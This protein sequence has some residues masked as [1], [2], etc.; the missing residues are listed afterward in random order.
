M[1]FPTDMNLF[2]MR[3]RLHHSQQFLNQVPKMPILDPGTFLKP[4]HVKGGK[5]IVFLTAGMIVEKEFQGKKRDAFEILIGFDGDKQKIW[6]M[7]DTAQ[8]VVVARFGDNT[9]EWISKQVT[10]DTFNKDVFG[11][12][13][14]IIFVVEQNVAQAQSPKASTAIGQGMQPVGGAATPI[15]QPINPDA[16]QPMDKLVGVLGQNRATMAGRQ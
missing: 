11:V 8:E 13:K 16:N 12:M 2:R 10:L 6:S 14:E 15:P 5:P 4:M 7:N 1:S 9:D 3:F